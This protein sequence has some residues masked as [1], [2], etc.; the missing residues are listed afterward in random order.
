M[1]TF[2]IGATVLFYSVRIC[3]LAL[4]F[5]GRTH[6]KSLPLLLIEIFVLGLII[7]QLNAPDKGTMPYHAK[8]QMGTALGTA[9][10]LLGALF[11]SWA[12]LSLGA[13]W[14]TWWAKNEM[15]NIVVTGPFKIVRH[16][17]YLGTWLFGI[18]FEIALWNWLAIG[19]FA[20]AFILVM[21]AILEER[22]LRA[23]FSQ[24][25]TDYAARTKRFIPY[26]L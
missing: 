15:R 11:S 22:N 14:Q 16:P 2:L 12:R 19:A 8:A 7:F 13:M 18:G 17:V 4:N 25:W 26:L 23:Q 1:I 10:A 5:Q 6:I 3:K 20:S 21:V 9:L 24:E